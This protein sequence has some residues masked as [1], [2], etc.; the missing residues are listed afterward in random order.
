MIASSEKQHQQNTK[1][2]VGYAGGPIISKI[3][4]LLPA[5][6]YRSSLVDSLITA[7]D[8]KTRCINITVKPSTNSE[9]SKFHDKAFIKYLMKRRST[10]DDEGMN[11]GE[12]NPQLNHALDILNRL[13]DVV[14]DDELSSDE[15]FSS[16]SSNDTDDE[17]ENKPVINQSFDEKFGLK[18][19]CPVFPYMSSYV[20][21]ICGA[22]ISCAKFLTRQYKINLEQSNNKGDNIDEKTS[23]LVAINWNGGRHHAKRAKA[24][25]FCYANDIVLGILE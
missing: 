22:T 19:D 7:L 14:K 15:E 2:I 20:R 18:F 21:I 10:T 8:L 6:E 25:G 13:D 5:N 9:L 24:S 1:S 3:C 4:D 11:G 16:D 12:L 23:T 17:L